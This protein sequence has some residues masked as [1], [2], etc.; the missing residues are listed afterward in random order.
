MAKRTPQIDAEVLACATVGMSV[1]A[2]AEKFS[3]SK[4]TISKILNEEK[5]GQKL[6]N[7]K[8][9]G[10][11]IVETE[12]RSNQKK[13]HSIINTIFDSLEED[14]KLA[15]VKDKRETLRVLVELFGMP[16]DE[17]LEVTEITV[18]VEDASEGE[19]K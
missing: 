16:E 1:R 14:I 11:E 3:L 2:I 19:P 12:R 17:E 5:N 15:S 6:I 18:T 4:T 13:A 9:I 7:A 8:K 10:Q